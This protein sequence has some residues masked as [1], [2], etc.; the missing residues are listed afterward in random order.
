MDE[1]SDGSPHVG[2][3]PKEASVSVGVWLII[4]IA[5][6]VVTCV[7]VR[8]MLI[9]PTAADSFQDRG[10]YGDWFGAINA[11]F[12]GLAF[13]GLIATLLLQREELRQNTSALHAQE[14]QLALQ[15]GA[16]N[17]QLAMMVRAAR[18]SSIPTLINQ[19]SLQVS[20]NPARKQS[21]PPESMS[22]EQLETE[23]HD[24]QNQL[25]RASEYQILY[26][27]EESQARNTEEKSLAHHKMNQIKPLL[28]NG[29]RLI[30]DLGTLAQY[31]RDLV[32]VYEELLTLK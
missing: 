26:L 27:V 31:R 24:V 15:S 17:A 30:K 7:W 6:A 10:T 14:N 20:S 8:W 32:K 21:H 4:I 23:M 28:A 13:A 9:I 18:L 1:S 3:R 19:Y 16:L 25:A 29:H 2:G 22:I 11:L 5:F 12:S